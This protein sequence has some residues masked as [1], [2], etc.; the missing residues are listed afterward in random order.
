M[1]MFELSFTNGDVIVTPKAFIGI[2]T[3][4][5]RRQGHALVTSKPL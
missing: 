1:K 4:D 5:Y 2:W 3:T